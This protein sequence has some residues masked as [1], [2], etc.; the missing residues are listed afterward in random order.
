MSV[1]LRTV[2]LFPEERFRKEYR[3]LLARVHEA[4]IESEVLCTQP[5]LS[6]ESLEEMINLDP[7]VLVVEV[8]SE[9]RH[10][11]SLLSQLHQQFPQTPILMVS[12]FLDPEFL[13]E[14]I[15]S[16]VQDALVRPLF[17]ER[18]Q[19]V[20]LKF[21]DRL[22]EERLVKTRTS[23]FS[24][25]GS[26]GGIGLTSLVA[27]LAV[28]LTKLSRK[29]TLIL[30]LDVQLGDAADFFGVQNSRYLIA[31]NSEA[32]FPD[33]GHIARTIVSHPKTDVD[34][35]S[36]TN[37]YSRKIRLRGTDVK[38]LLN[39]LR[40]K[41]D[42][43]LVDTSSRLGDPITAALDVSDL[44]FLV[45]KCTLPAIR[46][47]QRILQVFDQLAYAKNCIRLLINRY[48]KDDEISL[49][50]LEEA[51]RF[52]VYW[53]IPND[54]KPLIQ[55]I[56]LGEPLTCQSVSLPLSKVLYDMSAHVLAVDPIQNFTFRGGQ[57]SRAQA[58]AP[59][60]SLSLR[61][62]KEY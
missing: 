31:E 40:K 27:N 16:G 55:S 42:F 36:L 14:A 35:L 4:R 37:G 2:V 44:I 8:P 61:L 3:N 28:C 54:Y 26:K 45:S 9:R 13:I 58:A 15:R 6:N 1:K 30:D 25:F 39:H 7:E 33:F 48:C 56:E 62:F 53:A 59:S 22:L 21:Y 11:L 17:A 47:T 19:A 10:A 34:L 50:D 41:Y 43:I 60:S 24:F 49:K 32:S 52:K 5:T 57:R 29:K 12:D 18:L 38:H 51:L 23:V 46:N 20:F